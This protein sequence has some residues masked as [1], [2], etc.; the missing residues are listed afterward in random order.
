MD[1]VWT[2]QRLYEMKR[3]DLQ[4]EARLRRLVRKMSRRTARENHL[5]TWTLLVSDL[6]P[7]H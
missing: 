3:D 7:V 5:P 1:T 4:R 2:L 6:G